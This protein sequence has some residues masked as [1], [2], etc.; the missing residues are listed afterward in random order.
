M[1]VGF[2]TTVT[3]PP[4][5]HPRQPPLTLNPKTNFFSDAIP[6]LLRSAAGIR[7]ESSELR[8]RQTGD[9]FSTNK[10]TATSTNAASQLP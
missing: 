5:A 10:P 6:L 4:T 7:R 2:I 9:G 8:T 3:N 1:K